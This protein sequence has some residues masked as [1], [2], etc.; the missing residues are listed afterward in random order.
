MQKILARAPEHWKRTRGNDVMLSGTPHLRAPPTHTDS[1]LA[2]ILREYLEYE[3]EDWRARASSRRSLGPRS[4][5][6][7]TL[8]RDSRSEAA[9]MDP[10]HE[11]LFRYQF[12]L[13]RAAEYRLAVA[14]QATLHGGFGHWGGIAQAMLSDEAVR[15]SA[16]P[17][18][19]WHVFVQRASD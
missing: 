7:V 19:T 11:L 1:K 13:N 15:L 18:S 16:S 14:R 2:Y 8:F 12:L 9:S 5:K 10:A 17:R 6:S 4:R 3:R